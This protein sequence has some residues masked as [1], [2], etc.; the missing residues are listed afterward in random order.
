MNKTR[1]VID[2]NVWFSGI[3]WEG[4]PGQIVKLV[5]KGGL[6]PCF[7]PA[8]FDEWHE[9]IKPMAEK[10]GHGELYYQPR[11]YLL[12]FSVFVQPRQEIKVCRDPDDN[13]LL[14]TASEAKA[15]FLI[16]G[17]EDLLV[18][19]KFDLTQILTPSQFLEA[20]F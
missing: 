10:I 4:K 17:D 9:K 16:T 11:K 7:S 6:I 12:G 1:V 18:L 14:E 5:I 3:F 15:R 19:K 13:H 2:T 20:A 8:T